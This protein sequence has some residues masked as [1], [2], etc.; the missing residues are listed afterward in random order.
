MSEDSIGQYASQA[1]GSCGRIR[2]AVSTSLHHE[3]EIE[4][5]PE[6]SVEITIISVCTMVRCQSHPKCRSGQDRISFPLMRG[7]PKSY[8]GCIFLQFCMVLGSVMVMMA[9]GSVTSLLYSFPCLLGV[10]GVLCNV[11]FNSSTLSLANITA[12]Q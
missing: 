5:V 10:L 11:T 3:A 4:T 12:R 8:R 6:G 9:L 1:S 2:G 7:S